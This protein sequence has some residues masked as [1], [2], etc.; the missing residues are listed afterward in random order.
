[1]MAFIPNNV[2]SLC[3]PMEVG[4]ECKDYARPVGVE[5]VRE[6]IGIRPNN[7]QVILVLAAPAGITAAARKAAERGNVTI[8][9]EDELSKLERTL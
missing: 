7:R 1:M 5:V 4:V 8:W 2:V 3:N 6:L 9:D